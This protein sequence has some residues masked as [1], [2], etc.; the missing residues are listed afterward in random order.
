MSILKIAI[1][2]E[3][4]DSTPQDPSH[5]PEA[6]SPWIVKASLHTDQSVRSLSLTVASTLACQLLAKQQAR[7]WLSLGSP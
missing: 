4:R 6:S 3:R 1:V 5:N 7:K 2:E